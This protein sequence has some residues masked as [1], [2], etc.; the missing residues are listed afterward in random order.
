MKLI[1]FMLFFSITTLAVAQENEIKQTINLFFKGLQNGDTI[2]IK[3][4]INKEFSLK[5]LYT[6]NEG[7][8]V[9]KNESKEVFFNAVANKKEEDVWEEKLLSYAINIDANLATVWT[10]Y[11][12]YFNE[13][14]SHCGVNSFQLF[15][16]NGHWEIITI[17][18]TRRKENCD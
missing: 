12:F 6:N 17:V 1:L 4:T 8:S 7:R 11:R 10:P 14:F 5:T 16:N 3:E 15:N 18:D 13:K 2:T 9:L